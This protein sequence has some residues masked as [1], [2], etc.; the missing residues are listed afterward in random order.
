L[1]QILQSPKSGKLQLA[2]V[3]A[4]ALQEGY[5]LVR[6]AYSVVSPGTER[7]MM[8]FAR[9]SVLGKARSRPDLVRQFARKMRNDGPLATYRTAMSRLEI[10]QA[11]GYSCAG[12]VEAV[13]EGWSE[14]APGD[15]VA[16]AGAG[17]ANH[18]EFVVV[19]ENLVA[20]VPRDL[21][22]K[23]AAFAT[24]GAI[25]M[26]GLRIASP[27]LGEVAV[28]IGLG[29]IGQLAIQMLRANGCRVLGI[30]VAPERVEEALEQGAEWTYASNAIP[31]SWKDVATG[32]YGGDFALVT[33]ASSSAAPIHQ[34]AELCRQKGRVVLVGMMPMEL[35][36]QTFYDKELELR[37]STS[38]GPGRYDRSYEEIGLDY[39][40]PY[41]RWTENRNLR[42]FL[43]LVAS[44]AVDPG[45]LRTTEVPF[46]EAEAT[47]ERLS[48]GRNPSVAV[49]FRYDDAPDARREIRLA[50]VR[51]AVGTRPLG[52]SVFGA[53]NYARGMLL[54]LI[55]KQ[56]GLALRH[57]V[58]IA[59]AEAR[60]AAERFGFATCGTD[61][62]LALG[63]DVDLVV[64]ATRHDSH[65]ELA[66]QALRAGK[67]VWLEKPLALD[68]QG[69]SRVVEA[70]RDT[71]GFLTVGFNRRFSAHAR[72]IRSAFG[73]RSGP[74]SIHYTVAA[75][76]P[77]TAS[78]LMDPRE[79]GGRIVGE[80]CH[81]VDLC[82][83]LLGELPRSVFARRLSADPTRDDS[84]VILLQYPSGSLATIEYLSRTQQDLAKERF[85]VSG[86]NR[87]A[88]CENF[89]LT[90][91]NNARAV[92]TFNQD[93][94]QERA[95]AE[96]IAAI[97]RGAP[98]PLA[99]DEAVSATLATFAA[100]DSIRTGQAV[101]LES[102][103]HAGGGAK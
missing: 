87:T 21:D 24:I 20:P 103:W 37:M 17:Y 29:L 54:P 61:P 47:Y 2:E 101:D 28:V 5:V 60:D 1:K 58:A 34:A 57:V 68:T 94:G 7:L 13:G 98:S 72:A 62:A 46:A 11:L 92:R 66:E 99:I 16:C 42:S 23:R 40:L 6:N 79:G 77:P 90:R 44:G 73:Q 50:A 9:K 75:G 45:K 31:E 19:P 86:E 39:P 95:I 32:G 33:A 18:A 35:E 56:Q 64:I 78:W 48:E 84:S 43:A 96:V 38:Y 22:L 81:F 89:R 4:P 12:V 3:P 93:K 55:A 67:A 69:I 36:R 25:A 30:D 91:I 41:V 76:V 102:F 14:F 97:R 80:V 71:G 88:R 26:H 70:F 63:N 10:P 83:Y 53:G 100:E 49:A 8:E 65:A 85:E 59:G 51:E 82:S 15:H 27:T 74:L 52:V